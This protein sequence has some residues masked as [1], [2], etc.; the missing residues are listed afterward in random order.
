MFKTP[1]KYKSIKN[2]VKLNS[3]FIHGKDM[4]THKE[5]G[6]FKFYCILD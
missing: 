5:Y 1:Y 4:D 3:N 6:G 2:S